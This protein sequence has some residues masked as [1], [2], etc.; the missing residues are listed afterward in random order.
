[1]LVWLYILRPVWR[2][3]LEYGKHSLPVVATK[4][5]QID[6]IITSAKEGLIVDSNDVDQFI[7]AL[8]KLILDKFYRNEIALTLNKKIQRE[9]SEKN[10]IEKYIKWLISLF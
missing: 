6:K 10:I 2:S 5:G 8:N 4:V 9:Y 3:D 7:N 1:M